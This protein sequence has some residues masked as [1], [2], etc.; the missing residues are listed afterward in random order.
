MADEVGLLQLSPEI[1]DFNLS[2]FQDAV[3]G[4][5]GQFPVKGDDAADTTVGRLLFKHNVAATLPN[6]RK[7]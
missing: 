6:S 1:V 5:C 7:A 4:S 2:L 3:Q